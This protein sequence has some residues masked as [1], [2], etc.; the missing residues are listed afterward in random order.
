MKVNVND[1]L[2]VGYDEDESQSRN[3]RLPLSRT[4]PPGLEAIVLDGAVSLDVFSCAFGPHRSVFHLG[5]GMADRGV[6]VTRSTV[7]AGKQTAVFDF[8]DG[9]ASGKLTVEECLFS[10][11]ETSPGDGRANGHSHGDERECPVQGPRQPLPQF[12]GFLDH[13]HRH[14]D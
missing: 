4:T 7:L 2:F 9:N 5:N 12:Q 6:K 11:P 1:S 3:W 8:G 14:Q 10:R 13:G